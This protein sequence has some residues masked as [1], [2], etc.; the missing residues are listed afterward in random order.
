M[1]QNA[2][3]SNNSDLTQPLP[4]LLLNKHCIHIRASGWI[5]PLHSPLPLNLLQTPLQLESM[6][7]LS[8]HAKISEATVQML[9]TSF[10]PLILFPAV[11]LYYA[12]TLK[13]NAVCVLHWHWWLQMIITAFM[14]MCL[15]G[16]RDR[17][18]ETCLFNLQISGKHCYPMH[19]SMSLWLLWVLRWHVW[20]TQ[21]F[22]IS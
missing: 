16:S 8:A 6:H 18:G 15:K 1:L 21:T 3:R 22:N 7:A 9:S 19:L 12:I 14:K 5:K 17:F 4:L 2:S 13:K 10:R 20:A 11:S